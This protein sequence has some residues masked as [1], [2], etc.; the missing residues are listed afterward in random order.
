[1]I[2]PE[3]ITLIREEHA[4]CAS[5]EFRTNTITLRSFARSRTRATVF[6]GKSSQSGSLERSQR[7]RPGPTDIAFYDPFAALKTYC[8]DRCAGC[9]GPM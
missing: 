5:K 1:M 7:Q 8:L 3:R 2:S 4:G 6:F 9:S